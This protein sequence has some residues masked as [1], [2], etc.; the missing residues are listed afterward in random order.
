MGMENVCGSVESS[1]D[2]KASARL[3]V[4]NASIDPT[5]RI[6]VLHCCREDAGE[7]RVRDLIHEL[8]EY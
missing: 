5:R 6:V 7:Y 4:I 1:I 2:I 8:V 3:A